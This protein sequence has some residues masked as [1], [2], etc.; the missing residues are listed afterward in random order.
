MS[1][2][3]SQMSLLVPEG[4]SATGDSIHF[5]VRP[6]LRQLGIQCWGLTKYRAP[7]MYFFDIQMEGKWDAFPTTLADA[8][9]M[10][11]REFGLKMVTIT[12]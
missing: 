10:V 3:S 4:N 5:Q 2:Y 12:P 6:R 1:L 9:A 8:Q 7:R 11:L